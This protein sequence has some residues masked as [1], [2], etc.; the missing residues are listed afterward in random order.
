MKTMLNLPLLLLA[1]V[2]CGVAYPQEPGKVADPLASDASKV[3]TVAPP[4]EPSSAALGVHLVQLQYAEAK[5]LAESLQ[6]LFDESIKWGKLV[7]LSDTRGN[8]L[9]IKSDDQDYEAVR[10]LV[11]QLDVAV[12]AKSSPV[13]SQPLATYA[14]PAVHAAQET[15]RRIIQAIKDSAN[16]PAKSQSLRDQ[17]L[18]AVQSDFAEQQQQLQAD[19]VQ[20][21]AKIES[22][23]ALLEEREAQ[24]N[25]ICLKRIEAILAAPADARQSESNPLFKESHEAT[26]LRTNA[27]LDAARIPPGI[28][29]ILQGELT[30]EDGI[31]VKLNGELASLSRGISF[32]ISNLDNQTEFEVT[33]RNGNRASLKIKLECAQASEDFWKRI[34]LERVRLKVTQTDVDMAASSQMVA[35]CLYLPKEPGKGLSWIEASLIGPGVD[36]R[37]E[38]KEFGDPVVTMTLT[39][40]RAD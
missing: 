35:K 14:S 32:Q 33:S 7:I 8:R 9:I 36:I 18:K 10:K 2:L 22:L 39:R 27:N 21:R 15:Q 17:L 37:E 38:A 24:K 20:L 30:A 40:L 11:Q 28:D 26:R 6:K 4:R 13:Q 12:P 23:Q 5:D 19:L 16:D 1:S 29:A 25:A 3:L 34:L 31:Q